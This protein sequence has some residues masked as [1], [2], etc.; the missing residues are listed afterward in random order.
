M[1][2]DDD[3]YDLCDL[4]AQLSLEDMDGPIEGCVYCGGDVPDWDYACDICNR[5][6]AQR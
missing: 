2:I 4:L 1:E 5:L 6:A 3:I